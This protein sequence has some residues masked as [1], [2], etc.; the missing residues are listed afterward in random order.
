MTDQ[1]KLSG[2]LTQVEASDKRARTIEPR[3]L[4]LT[5]SNGTYIESGSIVQVS[6]FFLK[7]VATSKTV[8]H[9]LDGGTAIASIVVDETGHFVAEL[10]QQSQG[11]HEYTVLDLDGKESSAW[12]VTV[13]E[14]RQTSIEYVVGPNNELIENGSSTTHNSLQFAGWAPPRQVVELV[15]NGIVLR[16]LNVAE[17]GHWS[18]HLKDLR[19]GNHKFIAREL[20]GKES[21]PWEIL[22]EKQA[23]LSIQ[24]GYGQGNHQPIEDGETT[25]QTAVV[26]VGTAKAYE[27]GRILSD[28]HDGVDFDA[29]QYGIFT[30]LV[31][32]LQ[33]GFS[34]TFICRSGP[35]RVSEPWKIQVASSKLPQR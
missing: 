23:L 29:N 13:D 10:F 4:E 17:T 18:A 28:V 22:I 3:I 30:A 16:L 11:F 20:S 31:E 7:G 21:A 25:L 19:P 14:R 32:D 27:H 8:V 1:E 26:L 12:S 5:D 2:R 15:D 24:F 35:D 9:I 34:Y 6:D 33:P